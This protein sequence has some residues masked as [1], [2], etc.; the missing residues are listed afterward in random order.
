M[1]CLTYYHYV[2]RKLM[3]KKLDYPSLL[4][5]AKAIN[6]FGE[7]IR[8]A[9]QKEQYLLHRSPAHAKRGFTK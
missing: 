1:R 6:A 7:L 5:A 2:Q 4:G 3:G 8:T 9:P